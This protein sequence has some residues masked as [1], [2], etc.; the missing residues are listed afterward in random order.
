MLPVKFAIGL[1]WQF[2]KYELQYVWEEVSQN[3]SEK[4][5]VADSVPKT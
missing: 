1:F 5:A 2:Y 4:L 3:L